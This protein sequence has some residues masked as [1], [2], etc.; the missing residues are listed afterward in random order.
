MSQFPFM[1]ESKTTVPSIN[2]LSSTI[3]GSFVTVKSSDAFIFESKENAAKVIKVK[4]KIDNFFNIYSPNLLRC[5]VLSSHQ[6]H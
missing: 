2:G 1:F 3:E 5:Q 4:T 6:G